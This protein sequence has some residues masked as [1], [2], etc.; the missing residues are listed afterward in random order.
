M[1][2]FVP[3]LPLPMLMSPGMMQEPLPAFLP[4]TLATASEGDGGES[5]VGGVGGE[6]VL[7][8]A[9]AREVVNFSH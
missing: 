9:D 2:T 4:K 3:I 8:V 7:E 5:R 1:G 6:A